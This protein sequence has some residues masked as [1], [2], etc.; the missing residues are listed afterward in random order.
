MRGRQP[1]PWHADG[2]R[3]E[4]SHQA[5]FPMAVAGAGSP[6]RRSC[7]ALASPF[8][9]V[10]PQGRVQFRFKQLLDEAADPAANPSFQGIEPVIAK[11]MSSLGGINRCPR[12]I[13]RHGVISVG[14]P[15]PILFAFTSWRLRHLQISTTLAT[16]PS[17]LPPPSLLPP[18]RC[19]AA[20][21]SHPQ[22]RSE[23]MSGYPPP[24]LH[25]PEPGL[26][27][28]NNAAGR[29]SP[30]V[31]GRLRRCSRPARNSPSIS[32]RA[33]RRSNAGDGSFR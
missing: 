16:P 12:V 9:A 29:R 26:A 11:K 10:A 27:C 6:L 20:N 13:R 4:R 18:W 21:Y 25:L 33:P 23:R 5:A 8:I 24:P 30:H 32:E 14:V 2:R 22:S 3:P 28:A 19:S 17:R 15:T 7:A 31:D 1:R